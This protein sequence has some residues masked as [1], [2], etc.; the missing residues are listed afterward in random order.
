MLRKIFIVIIILSALSIHAEESDSTFIPLE[1]DTLLKVIDTTNQLPDT[2]TP[3]QRAY[4]HFL[5]RQ[6][7]R[8]EEQKI[9]EPEQVKTYLSVYDSLL[10]YLTTE[11]LNRR[12][13]IKQSFYRD[14]G[15]YFHRNPSFLV[16]DYQHTP[17]RKTIQPFTL[18]GNRLAVLYNGMSLNPFEHMIEPDG[19]VD[20]NDIPTT[21]GGAVYLLPG[22]VSQIFGGQQSAAIL[23]TVPKK[24]ESTIPES[25]FDIDKGAYDYS[26]T[27]GSYSKLFTD[28]KEVDFSVDYRKS[29]EMFSGTKDNSY[30]Y[31]GKT[32]IRLNDK[33]HL[34][35]SGNSL[36]R[37]GSFRVNRASSGTYYNRARTDRNAQIIIEK[38]NDARDK[39][40]RFG[41]S[42]LKQMSNLDVGYKGRF[43]YYGSGL[44]FSRES[45]HGSRLL[46]ADLELKQLK[47]DDDFDEFKRDYAKGS[48]TMMNQSENIRYAAAFGTEYMK[49]YRFLPFASFMLLNDNE[50]YMYMFSIGYSEK[51]PSLYE[52]NLKYQTSSVYSPLTDYA[53]VGN[54]WLE[55]EKQLIGSFLYQFGSK[56]NYIQLSL[57]GGK[58]FDGIDWHN[59]D[60]TIGA[61]IVKLYQPKNGDLEFFDINLTK[62]ISVKNAIQ[63]TAGGAYHIVNYAGFTNKAYQPDYQLFAGGELHFYW[64]QKWTDFF[65]YGEIVY[66]SAY[67]GYNGELLGETPVI[68]TGLS[69]VI[70]DFRFHYIFQNSLQSSYYNRAGNLYRSRFQYY[71]F[72][73]K[74]FN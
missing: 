59:T 38:H 63:L 51:A 65:A 26:F 18:A 8:Q 17:M 39:K 61:D 50:N 2:L 6:K 48:L 67:T 71:G 44:I 30:Q 19:M 45:I 12:D 4:Q 70:K 27:R 68:N 73:W 54:R 32:K 34:Y 5:D 57:N 64:K 66:T 24:P 36:R 33:Y 49:I 37:R 43:H 22:S 47:F 11:R 13:D 40:Y 41:Y 42:Y 9:I 14:V 21:S 55:S 56:K 28:G 35:A 16:L 20:A 10:V 62:K 23:L 46:K 72:T 58:I 52:I 1:T 3:A 53:N 74:F 15:D 29:S 60:T 31:T 7:V 69:F 25:S